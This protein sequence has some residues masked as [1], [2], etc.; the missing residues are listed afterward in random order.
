MLTDQHTDPTCATC[1]ATH[2]NEVLCD[3]C[4]KHMAIA[5]THRVECACTHCER[6]V[7]ASVALVRTTLVVSGLP[8][9]RRARVEIEGA[10]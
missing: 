4:A 7:D 2:Q 10:A 9:V 3:A 8:E 1:G 5:F 6:L